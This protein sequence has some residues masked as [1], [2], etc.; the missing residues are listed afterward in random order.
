MNCAVAVHSCYDQVAHTCLATSRDRR[1]HISGGP[2]PHGR[3]YAART[4]HQSRPSISPSD[5]CG[6]SQRPLR[7]VAGQ[8]PTPTPTGLRGGKPG[9]HIKTRGVPAGLLTRHAGS[10]AAAASAPPLLFPL[11]ASLPRRIPPPRPL[12]PRELARDGKAPAP[13]RCPSPPRALVA[14]QIGAGPCWFRA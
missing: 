3:H 10:T 13:L 11:L 7:S 12:P 8:P 14:P 5:D 4:C 6:S 2:P 1:I 9:D